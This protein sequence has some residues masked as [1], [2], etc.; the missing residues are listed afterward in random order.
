MDMTSFVLGLQA[1]KNAGGGSGGGSSDDVRYVTFMNHDGTV[2]LGKKA[3]AVGDDCADPIARGVFDTPTREST[4]QYDFSFVGWATTPNGAWDESALDAVTEDRTVYA[5]YASAVRYYTITF[6]DDDG[7]TV[8]KTDSV[9]YGS[10]PSY[11]P[12]KEGYTFVGW[13]P[14]LAAVTGDASYA[15][16]WIEKVDFASLTWAK[17]AEY[18]ENGKADLFELGATRT[19]TVSTYNAG[20]KT[21][22]AEIVG[23][24]HDDITGGGKAGLTLRLKNFPP[25]VTAW[26]AGGT[27][28]RNN[29]QWDSCDMRN[30]LS[31]TATSTKYGLPSDLQAVM[32][33]VVKKYY[34][35]N[36]SAYKTVNDNIFLPSASELGF[37]VYEDE[38]ECYEAFTE[39][40]TISDTNSDVACTSPEGGTYAN[41]Y[42]TRTKK[43][44]GY[45]YMISGNALIEHAQGSSVAYSHAYICI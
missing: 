11:T 39:K 33:T 28:E 12:T 7:T 14:A 40:S 38:G 2:E 36:D 16:T 5:A 22:T 20:N 8:L 32:K 15:A 13:T 21:V 34:D 24:N 31:S 10:T 43:A 23:I 41:N 44:S 29:K 30:T 26:S 25:S 45:A 42:W 9:A 35:L 1:G 18:A 6:Y 37:P 19:F 4:A 3:V 17:V 27:T